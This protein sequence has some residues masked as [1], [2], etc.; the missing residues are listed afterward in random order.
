MPL[1]FFIT[2]MFLFSACWMYFCLTDDRAGKGAVLMAGAAFG[3]NL[4]NFLYL[5]LRAN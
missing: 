3:I 2:F 1:V 5:I 4:M